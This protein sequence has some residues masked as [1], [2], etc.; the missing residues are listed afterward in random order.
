ME[1]IKLLDEGGD[2]MALAKEKSTGPTGANGG[3]LGYFGRG[4]MVPAFEKAAFTL[5]IGKYTSKPAKT[6]FGYHVIKLEERRKATPPPFDKVKDQFRQIILRERY[7]ELIEKT[8]AELKV[9]ILDDSLRL[10]KKE[11]E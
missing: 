10:K 9:E 6:E 5:K 1:I 8:R 11:A 7:G 2:F 3:D 4:Q